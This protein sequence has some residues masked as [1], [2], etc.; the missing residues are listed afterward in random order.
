MLVVFILQR[1]VL[2]VRQL[3]T[4]GIQNHKR[5]NA[6][7][8]EGRAILPHQRRIPSGS[9]PF[10]SID[11]HQDVVLLKNASDPQVPGQQPMHGLRVRAPIGSKTEQNIA[12]S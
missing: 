4:I 11:M 2:P 3:P 10:P 1:I 7:P 5:G 9:L 6:T 12:S 8:G